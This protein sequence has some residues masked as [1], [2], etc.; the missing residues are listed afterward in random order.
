LIGVD[1]YLPNELPDGVS[2]PSLGG[3]VR[4]ITSVEEFLREK[5]ATPGERIR[6]LTSSAAGNAGPQEQSRELATYE[7][8]VSAFVEVLDAAVPGDA[9]YIHYSGHGGRVPTLLPEVKSNGLDETLVPMDIGSPE[10]P[11]LRDLELAHILGRMADKGLVVTV[12]LDSCHSG[13]ATRGEGNVAVRGVTDVDRTP[14]PGTNRVAARAELAATW[15]GLSAGAGPDVRLG[16]GWLPEA[17]GYVLLAACRPSEAA[18]EYAFEGREKRGVLTYWLL[19]SL[20]QLRPGLTYKQ[21]YDRILGKIHSQFGGQTPMLLGEGDRLVFGSD[22]VASPYAVLVMQTDASGQ[23]VQL[24]VGRAQ[25]VGRGARFTIYPSDPAGL[26]QAGGRLALAEVDDTGATISWAKV[27][28]RFSA[29]AIEPGAQAVLL[30]PGQ[31]R[32]RHNVRVVTGSG[33]ER[34]PP[35]LK[36]FEEALAAAGSGWV[37]LAKEGQEIDYQVAANERGEYELWDPAGQPLA[38]M[39]PAIKARTADAAAQ[40]VRRLV[41]LSKYHSVQRL[42]NLD[43][44]S[45]LAHKLLVDLFKLPDGFHPEA[46]RLDPQPFET[47]NGRLTSPADEWLCL[48]IRNESSQVLNVTVLD[49]QPDWGISQIF[50]STEGNFFEPLDGGDKL[51][52]PLK[53]YLPPGYAEGTDVIKVFATVG[54]A[55]FRWLELPPLDSPPSRAWKRYTEP[56]DGLERLL[57]VFAAD[58]LQYRHINPAAYPSREWTTASVVLRVRRKAL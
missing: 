34:E 3:C 10:V 22:H 37:Q 23:R 1:Y 46:D 39:R 17:A 4:D 6:K 25:G 48:R 43:G 8:M 49:L 35:V 51:Q 29:D 38:N 26:A 16:S 58:R 19:D 54:A 33:A 55:N 7:N 45:P 36:Q 11:H 40:V 15:R 28:A 44:T 32:L 53:T 21:L 52:I 31:L 24:Q 13:G 27:T 14:R 2:Y 30:D 41:Q 50:P 5:L 57:T 9:V 47:G 20:K 42:D 56:A 18:Y 12:V